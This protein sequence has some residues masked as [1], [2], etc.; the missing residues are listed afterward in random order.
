V[1]V[2][3]TVSAATAHQFSRAMCS[4]SITDCS[5]CFQRHPQRSM[6]HQ[7]GK[8][9]N[10]DEN[11]VPIENSGLFSQ[12]EIRPERLKKITRSIERNAAHDIA[13]RSAEK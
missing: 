2:T 11:G 10:A 7:R 12:L 8:C 3:N 9:Q 5:H 4:E 6:K 1:K 13:E